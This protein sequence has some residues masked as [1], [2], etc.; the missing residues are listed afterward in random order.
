MKSKFPR[1]MLITVLIIVFV[2]LTT[3]IYITNTA[4]NIAP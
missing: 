1:S 3:I 4:P 2:Y